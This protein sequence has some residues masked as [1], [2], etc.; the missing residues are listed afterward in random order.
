[1]QTA[2]WKVQPA[3]RA[4]GTQ[5]ETP[6]AVFPSPREP[7]QPPCFPPCSSPTGSFTPDASSVRDPEPQP[8]PPPTRR[9][10]RRSRAAAEPPGAPCTD[11]GGRDA[12]PSLPF[13]PGKGE[14]EGQ[15]AGGPPRRPCPAARPHLPEPP[16]QTPRRHL[17]PSRRTAP[18]PPRRSRGRREA[19]ALRHRREG[20]GHRDRDRDGDRDGDVEPRLRSPAPG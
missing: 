13:A 18:P 11:G 14:D 15:E 4:S 9:A 2:G 1:M 3:F 20:D 5:R 6:S 7:G 8:P 16:P 17:V 19:P 12:A 10:T